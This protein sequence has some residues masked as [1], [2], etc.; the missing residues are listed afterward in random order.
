MTKTAAKTAGL[1]PDPDSDPDDDA[2]P[3]RTR[4]WIFLVSVGVVLSVVGGR[5]AWLGYETRTWP[6][7]EAEIVD[8]KVT[9]RVDPSSRGTPTIGL[10]SSGIRNEFASYGANFVYTVDGVRHL[11]HGIERG[12][13]GLQ[14]SAKSRELGLAHP[15]GSKAMVA[16]DPNDPTVAYLVPGIASAAKMVT[17]LGVAAIAIGLW[18]RAVSVPGPN[19][20]PRRRRRR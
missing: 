7:V 19:A 18:V 12:D 13:L 16:V 10:T 4:F 14:N 8:S 5:A 11:G 3:R 2:P 17:A 9:I 6:R 20:R 1:V 15:V